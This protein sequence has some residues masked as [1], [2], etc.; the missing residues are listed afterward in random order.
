[1]A[2]A[3]NLKLLPAAAPALSMSMLTKPAAVA[4]VAVAAGAEYPAAQYASKHAAV[5][6]ATELAVVVAAADGVVVGGGAGDVDWDCS[7]HIVFDDVEDVAT[8]LAPRKRMVVILR[9]RS[10]GSRADLF[11]FPTQWW[12]EALL[13]VVIYGDCHL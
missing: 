1:M 8:F 13:T 4:E 2:Q 7:V 3:K 11:S 9:S 12:R 6:A 5:A 10:L